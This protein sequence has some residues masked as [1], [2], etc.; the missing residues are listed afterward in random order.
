[1]AFNETNGTLKGMPTENR[2]IRFATIDGLNRED[3]PLAAEVWREDLRSEVWATRDMLRLATLLVR[4]MADA[5]PEHATLSYIE[6][7]CQLDRPQIQEALRLMRNYGAVE[8]F[9]LDGEVLRV[10]LNLSLLQRLRVLK[11]R[12]EFLELIGDASLAGRRFAIKDKPEWLPVPTGCSFEDEPDAKL[13]CATG[14]AA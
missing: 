10:A 9:S 4:Y 5:R 3:L 7:T 11:C 12:R 8:A 14:N 1:M 2:R 13:E 6:R